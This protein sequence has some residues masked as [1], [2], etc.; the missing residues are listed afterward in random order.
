L[1][2]YETWSLTLTEKHRLRVYENRMLRITFGHK[3]MEGDGCWRG[4]HNEELHNLEAPPNIIKSDKR[5]RWAGHVSGMGQMRNAYKI[6]A[7][8]YVGKR[9]FGKPRRRREDRGMGWEDVNWMRLAQ[10]RVQWWSLV[11]MVMNLQ[12]PYKER[13]LASEKDSAP[14]NWL[15]GWLVG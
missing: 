11:N 10:D 8:E 5:M 1:Y 2:E 4:L 9:P 15:V 7:G 6:L 14:W 13:H 12:V 3:T